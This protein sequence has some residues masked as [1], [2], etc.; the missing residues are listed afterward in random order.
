MLPEKMTTKDRILYAAMALFSQRGYDGVSVR[1][2]AQEVNIKASSLYKHYENKEAILESIFSLFKRSMAQTVLSEEEL[3]H[4]LKGLTPLK[5]L[6]DSFELFK[7]KMWT[8]EVLQISKII[9]LEQQRNQSIRQFF[10]EELIEKPRQYLKTV[11]DIMIKNG[12]IEKADTDLLAEEYNAYIIALYFQQCFLADQPD[13][14]QIEKR[15]KRH[16]AYFAEHVLRSRK[17]DYP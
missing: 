14:E 17:D 12:T 6:E 8:P 9:T 3:E 16:N 11:F 13:L 5:F 7:Q 4:L 15:M 10:R 1:D 2:I